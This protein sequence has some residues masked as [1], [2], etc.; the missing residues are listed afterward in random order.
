MESVCRRTLKVSL[1]GLLLELGFQHSTN[2]AHETLTEI[3]QSLIRQVGL[4]AHKYC[5][6]A[7]RV[8]P[9]IGDV[10]VAL[11][12]M[13]IAVEH[14]QAY[15]NKNGRVILP[16]LL[17][18]NHPK[19]VDNLH[20]G[21]VQ[22]HPPH[23]PKYFLPFPDPHT[24]L[25]TPT[26]SKP[27]IEYEILREKSS[28]HQSCVEKALT[29]FVTKTSETQSYFSK[30]DNN[31]FPLIP[32]QTEN[33][34]YLKALLTPDQ[35]FQFQEECYVPKPKRGCQTPNKKHFI[36]SIVHE[37]SKEQTNASDGEIIKNPYL[38][39][40]KIKLVRKKKQRKF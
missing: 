11:V 27:A 23:I 1:A 29:K 5:E 3:L 31:I 24:F 13:G 2:T 28:D 17:T 9:V 34:P 7:G 40:V 6:Q 18:A 37:N 20:V 33:P 16:P 19:R 12:D 39:P 4:S 26:H 30:N 32:C 10:I 21:E 15:G 35:M 38:S 8:Q 25:H 14:I 36:Y 22:P